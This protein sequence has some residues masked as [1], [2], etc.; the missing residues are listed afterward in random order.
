MMRIP[1]TI[2]AEASLKISTVPWPKIA[3]QQRRHEGQREVA[4]HDSG[5][6]G[7]DLE[8][9]FEEVANP[10]RGVLGE[11]DGRGQTYRERH[12]HRDRRS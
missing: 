12:Q 6:A 5:D 8:H 10:G 11:V 2:P 1:M 7:E 9:R 4:E 3:L